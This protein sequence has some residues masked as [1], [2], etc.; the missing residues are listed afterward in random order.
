MVCLESLDEGHP[1]VRCH[2]DVPRLVVAVL[3]EENPHG[4]AGMGVLAIECDVQAVVFPALMHVLSLVKGDKFQGVVPPALHL[5]S[6]FVHLA[7]SEVAQGVSPDV[8]AGSQQFLAEVPAVRQDV[9]RADAIPPRPAQ[10]RDGDVY[11]ALVGLRR[12]LASGGVFR[13]ALLVLGLPLGGRQAEIALAPLFAVDAEVYWN[14]GHAIGHAQDLQLV[15]Q[16][17]FRQHVV[18]HAAHELA[19]RRGLGKGGVIQDEA[20]H[21]LVEVHAIPTEYGHKV[22][23][24]GRKQPAPVHPRAPEHAVE[25]VLADCEQIVELRGIH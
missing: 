19:V 14:G 22:D 13:T 25:A 4:D 6:R 10:H 24:H 12:P 21:T 3:N 18:E 2:Q 23:G 5:V 1:G 15:A 11:L 20:G 17:A 16:H 9:L 7:H 8:G